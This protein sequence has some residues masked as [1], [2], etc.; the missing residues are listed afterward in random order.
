MAS[1]AWLLVYLND[2]RKL[3]VGVAYGPGEEDDAL[4]EVAEY[5][6]NE[7]AFLIEIDLDKAAKEAG[8][9]AKRKEK[10]SK[11]GTRR[12]FVCKET[13]EPKDFEGSPYDGICM[14]CFAD[15]TGGC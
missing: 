10:A 12:C 13:C 7:S 4:A 14:A 6:A 2:E 1:K 8:L 9:V 3:A 15:E 11:K 5:R